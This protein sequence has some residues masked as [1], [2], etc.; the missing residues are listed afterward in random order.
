MDFSPPLKKNHLFKFLSFH[1]AK[2]RADKDRVIF[3]IL[4]PDNT[5]TQLM[6]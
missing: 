1:Q 6:N 5:L 2:N 4:K 3:Y